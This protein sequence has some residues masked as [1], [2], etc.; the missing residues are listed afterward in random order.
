MSLDVSVPRARDAQED[1]HDSVESLGSLADALREVRR[2]YD[3]SDIGECSREYDRFAEGV[4]EY[5]EKEAQN[6]DDRVEELIDEF[7]MLKG[8]RRN[9]MSPTYNFGTM[10]E[11]PQGGFMS[12]TYNFG[13]Q[14]SGFEDVEI[15]SGDLNESLSDDSGDDSFGS[16]TQSKASYSGPSVYNPQI[17][18]SPTINISS[19]DEDFSF[20]QAF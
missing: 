4:A 10:G 19:K 2:S 17:N 5:M 18:F 1:L 14:S 15:T 13:N 9:F 16:L 7:S 8:E 20:D 11:V 12:P 6:M 3:I